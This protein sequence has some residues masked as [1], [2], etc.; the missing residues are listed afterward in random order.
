MIDD[1]IYL[2]R[3]F[4]AK[5]QRGSGLSSDLMT[6]FIEAG[7]ASAAKCCSLHVH[8]D[9]HAARRLYERLSFSPVVD[10]EAFDYQLMVRNLA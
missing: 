7:R 8:R 2:S 5:F 9:N 6:M 4:I 1:S 10:A 3:I